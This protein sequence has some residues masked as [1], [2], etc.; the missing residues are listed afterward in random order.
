[1][2]TTYRCLGDKIPIRVHRL[3]LATFVKFSDM[4]I[5]HIDGIKTNNH[6][7]NLEYVS[8]S[9]NSQ[10]ANQLGLV[11]N[12]YRKPVFKIIISTGVQI[13]YPSISN[14]AKSNNVSDYA[15]INRSRN[16]LIINGCQWGI[17][18]SP[19]DP[20]PEIS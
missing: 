10:H 8:K 14:A 17:V 1:V 13:T 15:I 5:N 19:S 3:V 12:R 4:E 16:G 18:T 2:F 20:Q 7:S 6:V 9:Q 11:K